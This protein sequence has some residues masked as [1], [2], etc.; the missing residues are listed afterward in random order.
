M[1]SRR[2]ERRKSSEYWKK[3][4]G[5]S[6][7]YIITSKEEFE[8]EGSDTDALMYVKIGLANNLRHRLESYMLYWPRGFFV[9]DVFYTKNKRNARKLE[10]SIHGYLNWK[11]TYVD[12]KHSHSEEWFELSRNN[13]S[14]VT[15]LINCNKNTRYNS[16]RV[17]PFESY[18]SVQWMFC[19]NLF[20]ASNRVK[21]MNRDLRDVLEGN[22]DFLPPQT[23]KDKL[24]KSEMNGRQKKKRKLFPE[25]LKD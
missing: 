14:S 24:R 3:F 19:S 22:I 13:I 6:G 12:E 10:K 9:F 4:E 11:A 1:T 17:L 18:E 2:Y 15:K 16:I 23:I 21:P 5:K 8:R 20:G 25:T 7:V